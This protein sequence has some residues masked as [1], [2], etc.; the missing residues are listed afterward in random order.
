MEPF[1]PLAPGRH[2]TGPRTA[3]CAWSRLDLR[4]ILLD[5]ELSHSHESYIA[6]GRGSRW[7]GLG[8]TICRMPVCSQ[9]IGVANFQLL[10]W[11]LSMCAIDLLPECW[12]ELDGDF[13]SPSA[14][15]TSPAS[16]S[17]SDLL[18]QCG[19]RIS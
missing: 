9:T 19:L 15:A 5:A 16:R 10:G 17:S 18:C 14:L 11:L 4:R 6:I 7:L 1:K 3:C 2:T 13:S 8:A 12:V